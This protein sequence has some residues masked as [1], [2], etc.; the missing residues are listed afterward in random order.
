MA[1]IS[2]VRV[3]GPLPAVDRKSAI[4]DALTHFIETMRL[5]P[6][7]QLPSERE[8]MEALRV[9]RRRREVIPDWLALDIVEVR[10]GSALL[11]RPV[12]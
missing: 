7:D 12:S 3:L 2:E 5:R 6:G 1:A 9:G 11:K 8:L 10:K 4:L